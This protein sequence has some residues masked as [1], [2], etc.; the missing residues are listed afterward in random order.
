MNWN[1]ISI[2]DQLPEFHEEVV[3]KNDMMK[4]VGYLD[5]INKNGPV[6]LQ[7]RNGSMKVTHW[8]P[9]PEE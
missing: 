1:W 3:I 2:E 7:N 4:A 9:L 8:F 6:F 5:S